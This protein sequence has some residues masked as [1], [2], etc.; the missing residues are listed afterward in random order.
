ML[1]SHTEISIST[2]DDLDIKNEDME[3]Y[4][5]VIKNQSSDLKLF[6]IW[7]INSHHFKLFT[8]FKQNNMVKQTSYAFLCYCFLL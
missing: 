2:S 8:L 3:E 5:W 6:A 7:F 4:C 1:C